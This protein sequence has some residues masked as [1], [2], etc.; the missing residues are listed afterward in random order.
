MPMLERTAASLESCHLQRVLP[1]TNTPYKSSRRLHTAFWQH[2]AADIELSNVWQALIREPLAS[3][4]P[5]PTSQSSSSNR[6]ESLNASAFLLDFL[7]PQSATSLLRK[8]SP[9]FLG[10]YERPRL[11]LRS[12]LPRLFTSSASSFQQ[13]RESAEEAA[14][15]AVSQLASARDGA[16]SRSQGAPESTV[17]ETAIL[18]GGP[19]TQDG[20][21]GP[22]EH[23]REDDRVK[24][25]TLNV[26]PSARAVA[27]QQDEAFKVADAGSDTMR[28]KGEPRS[29]GQA[30]NDALT[31]QS[32][33]DLLNLN[34]NGHRFE[35]IWCRFHAIT[36]ADEFRSQF[37]D[38]VTKYKSMTNL[39]AKSLLDGHWRTLWQIW[40]RNTEAH[41]ADVEAIDWE[42]F[43]SHTKFEKMM[44]RLAPLIEEIYRSE[45]VA[46]SSADLELSQTLRSRF[47]YPIIQRYHSKFRWQ[48]YLHL[49][50]LLKDPLLY[51]LFLAHT[52]SSPQLRKLSDELYKEYRSVPG[53]KIR[54]H[55]MRAM[56]H[57]VYAPMRN[58]E[59]MK[60]VHEDMY[61]RFERLDTGLYRA[62]INFYGRQGDV[63]ATQRYFDEYRSHYAEQRK[64]K[65]QISPSHFPDFLYLLQLYALRGELGEARRIFSQAQ[66]DF[67]PTLDIR[68]WN[69]LLN[70]HAKAREYDA[71]IRVFGVLKQ[72]V[73]ADHYTYGTIMGMCGSRG[74]LEFTLELYHM[75]KSEG[76]QPNVTMVD[77]VVEAYCQN[78][79]F[80][81]AENIV[82][83]TT[84]RRR[85]VKREL[86]VLWNSLLWHHA[87]RRDLQTLNETLKK[88]TEEYRI[89]YNDKTYSHLLRALAWCKQ[90]HHALFLLQEAVKTRAFKP[91]LEHYT[92][93]MSAF[94]M[95]GQPKELLRTSAILRS[96]GMPQTGDLL[97]R[98]LQALS[99]WA[100]KIRYSN[101]DQSQKYLVT[102]LRQFRKSIEWSKDSTENIPEHPPKVMEPWIQHDPKPTTVAMR[103]EHTN[104]LI[105]TF[106]LMRQATDIKGIIELWQSSSPETSSMTEPPLRLLHGLMHSAFYEGNYDEVRQLWRIVFDRAVQM[107]RVSAPGTQREET[108]AALRYML[109]DPLKTMQRMHG[110]TQDPDGLQHTVRSVLRA[111]FRLDSKN[112]NFYVQLLAD[113]KRWREAFIVCEEQLMPYWRGWARVRAKTKGAA[114]RIP[115]DV[116]RKSLNPHNPRPISYTLMVLSKAY[117]DLELMA[118]WSG[119]AER[120]LAYIV[121]KCP[122]SIA[123]VRSAIRTNMPLENTILSGGK[124]KD[125]SLKSDAEI[126]EE[127]E[128]QQRRDEARRRS[129]RTADMPQ[130]FKEMM[131]KSVHEDARMS[132][133]QDWGIE[134]ESQ[135]DS[136][137]EAATTG[138]IESIADA[139]TTDVEQEDDWYDIDEQDDDDYTPMYSDQSQADSTELR[140]AEAA[141]FSGKVKPVSSTTADAEG[142]RSTPFA[143]QDAFLEAHV[144]QTKRSQSKSRAGK[145]SSAG[146][147]HGLERNQLKARGKK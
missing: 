44:E 139:S 145:V 36:E 65:Q 11:Y 51:E 110:V 62:Y 55:V 58:T 46:V 41:R 18:A 144:R 85:F 21:S 129:R 126:R 147:P 128:A 123:A 45:E 111:G 48:D 31:R 43:Q 119:E 10:S 98:V 59:G 73:T 22:E 133:E 138:T 82:K 130:S 39:L 53:V 42:E 37:M 99:A 106:T 107:A 115:V 12:T 117:M 93:L 23:V 121:H 112:W 77:C 122:A 91:T 64:V 135:P 79:K 92:L 67:G 2:G 131:E 86:T 132:P 127:I 28:D 70:A 7:Y 29:G 120:L 69:V 5:F 25:D 124:P 143:A 15:N 116:R 20:V 109:T 33:R 6:S 78:D 40:A 88:M 102:A 1:P 90:P 136:E 17:A 103:T 50:K 4:N 52:T 74:D 113:L 108:L 54:G 34:D 75:S 137:A 14:A 13:S 101:P 27:G 125:T 47:V 9:S 134:D 26:D 60:L 80:K 104:V 87:S 30:E 89:P 81:E 66:S 94:I 100:T 142:N 57:H 72:A 32:L 61:G 68:C 8:L 114:T 95:T 3:F 63:R 16:T 118:S 71:A 24:L 83:I 76:L 49:P 146:A 97:L 96:L 35:R 56:V 141:I 38:Y 84:E 140:D 105:H 19:W